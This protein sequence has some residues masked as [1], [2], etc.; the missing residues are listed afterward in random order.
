MKDFHLHLSGSTNP[1]L[2]WELVRESGYKVKSKDYFDFEQTLLMDRS[3]VDS[4]DSYLEILHRID[5]A[6]SFPRAI[7]LCVY[8]A[9]KSSYLAGCTELQLRWNPVKRSQNQ[10]IDLDTLIVAARAGAE[11]AK[12]Y[13]GISGSMILCMGRDLD[14]AANAAIFN[15]ALQYNSKGIIGIDIAGPETQTLQSEFTG[16]FSTART[17]GMVTTVHTGETSHPGVED[18][19]A[20]VL[21][22]LRPV[23]I[24]HGIQIYKFPK[25]MKRASTLGV[26]FEICLTSN[27]T[28]RAARDRAELF[29]ILKT[30]EEFQL[31]YTICTDAT[32][33]LKTD[34]RKEHA[35]HEE[36]KKLS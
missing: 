33:L 8:D 26:I 27:L 3:K 24:G 1:V 7:E 14:A 29:Q 4:L 16:Y 15:K 21:E 11:R 25:L 28:T 2:L 31:P 35:L 22:K 10:K 5:E 36:I 30:F 17:L 12:N 9:Y 32:Y 13:F 23:R 20:F 18:E 19:L 34:L 6:Q